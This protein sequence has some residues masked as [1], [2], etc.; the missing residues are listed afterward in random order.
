MRVLAIT[1]CPLWEHDDGRRE[2]GMQAVAVAPRVI[3]WVNVLTVEI[4]GER[5]DLLLT[6][7]AS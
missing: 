2:V 6:L 1:T 5:H 7:D 3:G 4:N